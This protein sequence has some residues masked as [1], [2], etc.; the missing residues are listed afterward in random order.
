MRYFRRSQDVTDKQFIANLMLGGVEHI[1]TRF[2][3]HEVKVKEVRSRAAMILNI[4]L[5]ISSSLLRRV[6]C[7]LISYDL[8]TLHDE[9]DPLKFGDI[10]YRV[11]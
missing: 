5:E 10:G 6:I 9:F 11:T 2:A 8:S 4:V 1:C 7:Y 3:N